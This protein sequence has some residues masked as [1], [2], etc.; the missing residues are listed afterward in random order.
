[1]SEKLR[2]AALAYKNNQSNISMVKGSEKFAAELI[3]SVCND[4]VK[5]AVERNLELFPERVKAIITNISI[6]SGY[7][8]CGV[9]GEDDSG[10]VCQIVVGV[11]SDFQP[12]VQFRGHKYGKDEINLD[13][14]DLESDI[15]RVLGEYTKSAHK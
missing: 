12:Y 13:I 2:W 14:D 6:V 9:Y 1:M 8:T 15:N 7:T 3:D 5:P 4:I 11:D 10:L